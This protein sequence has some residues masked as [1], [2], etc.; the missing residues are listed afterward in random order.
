MMFFISCQ[1]ADTLIAAHALFYAIREACHEAF[2]D[3]GSIRGGEHFPAVISNA[4]S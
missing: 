3:T 4:V 1:R 2:V